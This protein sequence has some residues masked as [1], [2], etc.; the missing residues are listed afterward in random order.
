MIERDA[1][2]VVLIDGA[3]IGPFDSERAAR[4]WLQGFGFTA[5][6]DVTVHRER[7]RRRFRVV[8]GEAA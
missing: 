3:A 5:A 4:Q 8:R 2:F 6:V 1:T 7:K